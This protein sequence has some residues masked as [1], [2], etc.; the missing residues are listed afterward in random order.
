MGEFKSYRDLEVWQQSMRVARQIY[1]VT[2]EFPKEEKFGLTSQM[3]RAAVSIPS[4]LAEGHARTGASEFLHFISIAL[5]S[6]AELETQVI[7]SSDLGFIAQEEQTD[8]LNQ[9][10]SVGRMLRGLQKSL[11]MRK[12]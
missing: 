3:R 7:L 10:A 8:L 12:K 2:M 1:L 11:Q 4:N 9:L 6:V 5:G